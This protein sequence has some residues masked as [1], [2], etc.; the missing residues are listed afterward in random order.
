M[1]ICDAHKRASLPTERMVQCRKVL[2]GLAFLHD[3]HQIHRDIKPANLLINHLGA[4]T[5]QCEYSARPQAYTLA[6]GRSD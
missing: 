5:L 2:Q 1:I 6:V 3:K 4:P